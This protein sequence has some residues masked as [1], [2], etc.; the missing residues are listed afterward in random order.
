MILEKARNVASRDDILEE[1]HESS[2]ILPMT[3]C[4]N[5]PKLPGQD[6]S[7]FN[8]WP[9]KVQVNRKGL[10]LEVDKG[11]IKFI[12]KLIEVAKENKLFE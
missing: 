4:K 2:P 6:T 7:Q 3:F 11:E 9:W 1:K 10:H 8:N 5:F 12:G